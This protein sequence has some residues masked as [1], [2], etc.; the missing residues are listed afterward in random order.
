VGTQLTA[1]TTAGFLITMVSIRLIPGIAER[2][3]WQWAFVALA[4]GPLF[5]IWA[6]A[7]LRRS[8]GASRMAGG[9]G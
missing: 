8:P 5:G 6:M 4:I 1:Q 2:V 3:G 9:R 7:L